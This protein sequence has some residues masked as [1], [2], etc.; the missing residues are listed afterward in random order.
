MSLE[1]R[2]FEDVE[3]FDTKIANVN[4]ALSQNQIFQYYWGLCNKTYFGRHQCF[5]IVSYLAFIAENHYKPSL[6][7]W[8]KAEAYPSGARCV[9]IRCL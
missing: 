8:S 2:Q 7:F 5:K 1:Q 9:I 3:A 4:T 6:I